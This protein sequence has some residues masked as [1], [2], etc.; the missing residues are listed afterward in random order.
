M[1]LKKKDVIAVITEKSE[2]ICNK[3]AT[4]QEWVALGNKSKLFTEDRLKDA[5]TL[6]F[7]DR[8]DTRLKAQ[9]AR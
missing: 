3:C 7:C 2:L 9:P 6:F 5:D 1:E 4:D 8:C